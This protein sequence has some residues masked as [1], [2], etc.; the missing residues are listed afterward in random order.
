M[1][2]NPLIFTSEQ[3]SHAHSLETLNQLGRYEEFMRSINTL[4]DVG[5]GTGKD[6]EWW[7][8][9]AIEDDEGNSIPLNIKCTGIDVQEKLTVAQQYPNI[10][11]ERHDFE[12]QPYKTN[13]YDVLWCHDAF[14]YALNPLNTLRNFYNMLTTNGMLGIVVPQSTN[15]VY[16]KQAYDQLNGQYFNY[17][18]VSLIH[19]LAVSGFDCRAGF[20]KKNYEDPW[21]HAVVYKSDYEPMDPRTTTWMDLAEKELLPDSA[22]NSVNRCGHVRQED[23]VLAWL[24]R[25]NKAYKNQ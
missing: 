14:Q 7:A 22:T 16:H 4:C 8:T 25:S 6:L 3:E 15:I 10:V 2:Q 11:Y 5:C 23:L 20:F 17:T 9:R 24:D 1:L 13:A 19:M 12:D 21:I 18:L